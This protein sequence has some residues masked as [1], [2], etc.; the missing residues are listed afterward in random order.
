MDMEIKKQSNVQI[1]EL[2]NT[3]DKMYSQTVKFFKEQYNISSSENNKPKYQY[4]NNNSDIFGSYNLNQNLIKIKKTNNETQEFG[5]SAHEYAHYLRKS[6]NKD[7]NFSFVPL[8]IN[9]KII[10]QAFEESFSYFSQY[11]MANLNLPYNKVNSAIFSDL[12]ELLDSKQ[13]PNDLLNQM[14]KFHKNN[15][16][17]SNFNI[18]SM[19]FVTYNDIYETIATIGVSITLLSF[20]VNNLNILKTAKF[21]FRPWNEISNDLI[22]FA[23]SNKN[24]S[25]HK[26]FELINFQRK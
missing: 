23:K 5:L 8:N 14:K 7:N 16:K 26:I 20:T 4:F 19:K 25:T 17:S 11:H 6:K 24:K 9:D 12:V 2:S 22:K 13:N 18:S 15:T 1:Q 21:L 10:K 3:F